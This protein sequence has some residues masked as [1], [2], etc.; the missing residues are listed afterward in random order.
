MNENDWLP[1][2]NLVCRQ[3]GILLHVS[4]TESG[5]FQSIT[6]FIPKAFARSVNIWI[7][8]DSKGHVIENISDGS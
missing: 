2:P 6:S 7:K 5:L 1:V 8:I 3:C 4:A